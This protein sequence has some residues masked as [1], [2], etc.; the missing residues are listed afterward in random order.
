MLLLGL[1]VGVF[2][3]LGLFQVQRMWMREFPSKSGVEI[4]ADNAWSE[5]FFQA[6]ELDDVSPD[7]YA[8]SQTMEDAARETV[9][10]WE[11]PADWWRQD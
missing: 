11:R 9:E 1:S 2:L 4:P 8:D 6:G 5:N 7:L 3:G 10:P